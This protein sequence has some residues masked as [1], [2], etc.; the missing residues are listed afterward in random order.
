MR[1][2]AC[3]R[4]DKDSH[5]CSCAELLQLVNV[6]RKI[7]LAIMHSLL[8]N[9][10]QITLYYLL[11]RF[12][13]CFF[14]APPHLPKHAHSWDDLPEGAEASWW[15]LVDHV[16]GSELLEANGTLTSMMMMM[17]MMMMVMVLVL[18]LVLVLV[19]WCGAGDAGGGGGGQTNMMEY[20]NMRCTR[21]IRSQMQRCLK[22]EAGELVRSQDGQAPDWCMS[23]TVSSECSRLMCQHKKENMLSQ[24]VFVSFQLKLQSY[25]LHSISNIQFKLIKHP[26]IQLNSSWILLNLSPSPRCVSPTSLWAFVNKR[27]KLSWGEVS[28]SVSASAARMR[29]GEVSQFHLRL[30][31]G[32]RCISIR[33]IHGT[34]IFTMVM[35]LHLGCKIL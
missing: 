16:F 17:M 14:L 23:H 4:K 8:L 5:F 25:W 1:K 21:I 15:I 27:V 10:H 29:G 11:L 7:D 12:E 24:S 33:R 9:Q 32:M 22:S 3:V 30:G 20:M 26:D 6:I 13:T 19:C 2:P 35:C 18:V 31:E 34:G 28:D